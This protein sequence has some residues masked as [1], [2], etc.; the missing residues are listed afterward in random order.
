MSIRTKLVIAFVGLSFIPV[1]LVG[2]YGIASNV[3]NLRRSALEDLT[4]DVEMIRA[5]AGNFLAGVENDLLVVRHFS[6]MNDYISTYEQT[7]E[8]QHH[9]LVLQRLASELMSFAKTK[10]IYYRLSLFSEDQEELLRVECDDIAD[11]VSRF[12]FSS[13]ADLPDGGGAL[14]FLLAKNLTGTRITFAPAELTYRSSAQLP[15]LNFIM[16]LF[17]DHHRVGL[18]VGS[19]FAGRLF[20]AMHSAQNLKE[21]E[22]IVL[23][24]SEGYYYYNSDLK[25]DWNK[26]I[27]RRMEGNLHNDYPPEVG[28]K[29][30]SGA[31]GIITD[32]IDQ[33]IAYAPLFPQ[34]S[35]VAPGEEQ[36]GIKESFY[37][38]KSVPGATITAPARSFAWA[39]AGFL[40]IF[41]C[42]AAG[43]GIIATRKFT[44]PIAEVARGAGIISRGDY[45]YRLNVRTGDEIEHLAARFND[46]AGSLEAHEDEIAYH[47]MKLE[48]MVKVRTS[49]LIEEKAKLRAILDNVPNAF[50]LL[51]RDFHIEAV[52]EAF[53]EIVGAQLGDERGKDGFDVFSR[54]GFCKAD[55]RAI[56][57]RGIIESHTDQKIDHAGNHRLIEHITIPLVKDTSAGSIVMIMTDITRR[58]RLEQQLIQ[59]EKLMATGEMSAIIAHEFRNALTS[60]KM[61]LQLQQEDRGQSEDT[62]KSLGVALDSIYHMETVVKELLNFARPSPM[63]FHTASIEA[64]IE[65]SLSFIKLRIHRQNI[66]V[67]REIEHELPQ[68]VADTVR[69]KEAIVNLLLNAIQAIEEKELQIGAEEIRVVVKRIVLSRTLRDFSSFD[70]EHDGH[71]V[72]GSQHEIVLPKGEKCVLIAIGDSGPG[73]DR[74]LMRRVFDPFFTTKSNGTGLGLPMVKQTV[75]AHGGIVVVKSTKGKGSTFEIV[76]PLVR[77][78][79]IEK[80]LVERSGEVAT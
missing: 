31:E 48:E 66:A 76:L 51:D 53:A 52:S 23:A 24:G 77:Q 79:I 55:L 72:A 71:P 64:I 35:G 26:L 69:M 21:D 39:F 38:F 75:N 78:K 1:M 33:I 62:R 59:S 6:A 54:V 63:E 45:K 28:R 15:V 19:V 68:V 7:G 8:R 37:L 2:L 25:T 5:N 43:L 18:L 14:Y 65:D 50:V 32:G 10:K 27:A 11:S 29:I 57:Q 20:E 56:V 36:I 34:K 42:V 46:M 74:D 47:R 58:K 80:P 22:K 3:R 70:Q 40:M 13:G 60:I 61:I 73:I 12:H 44:M 4:H 16:P 9:E 49:E 17:G 41:L 67:V 30:L